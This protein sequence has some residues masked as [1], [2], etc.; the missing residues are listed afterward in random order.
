MED[1]L[2]L[3]VHADR[4]W[5]KVDTS[6]KD[7]C[8][9]W[10]A[11]AKTIWGYGVFAVSPVYGNEGAHRMAFMLSNKRPIPKGL[12]VMHSCDNPACC[13]PAHLTLGTPMDNMRD[14]IAKGRDRHVGHAGEANG[15]AK[16]TTSDIA[17]IRE[18]KLSD[19]KEAALRGVS[20]AHIRRIRKGVAWKTAA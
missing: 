18:S 14:M 17:S 13:N 6:S 8:W 5:S 7:G 4:F 19:R 10:I 16:L 12:F 3:A 15:R 11:R 2:D 20:H 1:S 9:P